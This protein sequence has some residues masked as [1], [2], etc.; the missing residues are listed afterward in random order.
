MGWRSSSERDSNV[1]VWS[2]CHGSSQAVMDGVKVQDGSES[3][4]LHVLRA[5]RW[6]VRLGARM[7]A[8]RVVSVSTRVSRGKIDV[9]SPGGNVHERSKQTED[10]RARVE[11]VFLSQAQLP[12]LASCQ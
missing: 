3:G 9:R 11:C 8:L 2:G 10:S 7:R 12:P 1:W 5:S 6:A 4:A